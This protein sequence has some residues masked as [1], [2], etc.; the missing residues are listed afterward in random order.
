MNKAW[1]I[2]VAGVGAMTPALVL[3]VTVLAA[4]APASAA[5][6]RSTCS[7]T[8]DQ[9]ALKNR[10][11]ALSPTQKLRIAG[12][13]IRLSENALKRPRTEEKEMIT[14]V[15]TQTQVA[16]CVMAPGGVQQKNTMT[17]RGGTQRAH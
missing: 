10:L 9:D 13:R 15:Q 14:G 12:D 6:Q 5:A 4:V 7:F 8:E 1:R 11:L 17:V 2:L 3:N 16:R